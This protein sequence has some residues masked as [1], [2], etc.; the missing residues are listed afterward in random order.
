MFVVC[1][2]CVRHVR[3]S[4][5]SCPFCRA[6]VVI[7]VAAATVACGKTTPPPPEPDAA[8][9]QT[10]DIYGAPPVVP[11]AGADDPARQLTLY[12]G[13]PVPKKK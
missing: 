10:A 8:Q 9:R 2:Q 7:A 13:P 12:G 4:E 3:D 11:D 5:R 6:V 1:K